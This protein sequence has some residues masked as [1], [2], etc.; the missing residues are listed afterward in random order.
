MQHRIDGRLFAVGVLD[1]L[2]SGVSSVYLIY[3]P[4]FAFVKPGIVSAIEEIEF[5]KKE[6]TSPE[7]NYYYMG[8]YVPTCKKMVYKGEYRPSELLCPL[9]FNWARLD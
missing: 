6:N 1:I 8:F 7:F 9:T 2:P 4:I 5:V 3:D